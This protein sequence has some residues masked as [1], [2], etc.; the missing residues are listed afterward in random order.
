MPDPVKANIS[1]L[2]VAGGEGRNTPPPGTL[3]LSP[4]RKVA[5]GRNHDFLFVSINVLA[6]AGEGRA[7]RLAQVAAQAFYGTPGSVTAALRQATMVVNQELV[8]G[9]LEASMVMGALRSQNLYSSEC[10]AGATILVRSGNVSR[11][12]G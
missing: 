5:R 1:L 4:P 9:K 6:N 8:D 7:S 12:Y 11:S 10:G 3:A 2:H